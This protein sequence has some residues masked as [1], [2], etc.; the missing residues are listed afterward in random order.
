MIHILRDASIRTK[1]LSTYILLIALPTLL[2]AGLFSST[3]YEL[4]VQPPLRQP[5]SRSQQ[6][7][8]Q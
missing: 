1:L 2:I 4:R 7:L 5:L 3:L 6:Y 8:R